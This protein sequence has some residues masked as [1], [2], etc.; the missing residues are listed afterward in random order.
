MNINIPFTLWLSDKKTLRKKKYFRPD[1]P[2]TLRIEDWT[3][4]RVSRKNYVTLFIIK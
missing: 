2:N 4:I 3:F 1:N